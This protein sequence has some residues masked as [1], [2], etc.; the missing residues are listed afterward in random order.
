MH[1]IYTHIHV[2]MNHCTIRLPFC[3]IQATTTT[4]RTKKPQNKTK[5]K[6]SKHIVVNE[7]HWLDSEFP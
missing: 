6:Q 7:L 3:M 1:G 2:Y 5:K 4:T